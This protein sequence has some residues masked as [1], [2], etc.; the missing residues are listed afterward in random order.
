MKTEITNISDIFTK[1]HTK[2]IGIAVQSNLHS[3]ILKQTVIIVC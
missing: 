3:P 2:F 1:S